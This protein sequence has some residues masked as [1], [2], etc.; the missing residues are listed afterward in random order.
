MHGGVQDRRK[1]QGR[2][3]SIKD[4]E[5]KKDETLYRSSQPIE[6]KGIHN[7]PPEDSEEGLQGKNPHE[8]NRKAKEDQDCSLQEFAPE[9][10]HSSQ[11]LV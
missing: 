8:F 2:K 6:A 4:A 9:I 5:V 1:G 10:R 11:G 7:S 3:S